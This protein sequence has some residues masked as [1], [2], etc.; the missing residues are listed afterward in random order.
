MITM[1]SIMNVVFSTA[2][3]TVAVESTADN[4]VVEGRTGIVAEAAW[5]SAMEVRPS[6]ILTYSTQVSS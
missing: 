6:Y 3:G 5:P 4:A 2:A 1:K